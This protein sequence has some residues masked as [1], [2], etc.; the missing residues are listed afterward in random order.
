M[1]EDLKLP[2]G[3][4]FHHTLYYRRWYKSTEHTNDWRESL[5]MIVPMRRIKNQDE[6]QKLHNN[7]EPEE[8]P[9]ELLAGYAI[10]VCDRLAREEMT[11]LEAFKTMRDELHDLSKSRSKRALGR[12]AVR[13][14]RY[15]DL[16]LEHMCEVPL[17]DT[18]PSSA[19]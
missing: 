1:I 6:H 9:S 5:A 16:Q 11:R 15:F 13:F 10:G 17:P 14:V 12:E 18:E 2:R 3:W 7:V 19:V 8:L 4:D